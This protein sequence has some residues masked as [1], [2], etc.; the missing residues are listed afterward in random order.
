MFLDRLH[1]IRLSVTIQEQITDRPEM[2]ANGGCRYT[3]DRT[4]HV[5]AGIAAMQP[6]RS[7]PNIRL[8]EHLVALKPAI[9]QPIP[10][11]GSI[12]TRPESPKVPASPSHVLVAG[13]PLPSCVLYGLVLG[14]KSVPAGAWAKRSHDAASG[15]SHNVRG[16]RMRQA[17]SLCLTCVH[18]QTPA[19]IHDSLNRT[20]DLEPQRHPQMI[21]YDGAE[22]DV[23]EP[24]PPRGFGGLA[25]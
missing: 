2:C 19:V 24:I 1:S 16:L 25:L 11:P 8:A 15:L 13:V 3:L 17:I 9:H 18:Q 7:D 10:P 14:H 22:L 5:G 21:R 6:R 20:G 23:R 4:A 12:W